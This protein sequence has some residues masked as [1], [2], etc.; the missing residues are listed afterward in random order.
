MSLWSLLTVTFFFLHISMHL[1]LSIILNLTTCGFF[2]RRFFLHIF[3][4]QSFHYG[5]SR[6]AIFFCNAV[7]VWV[8]IFILYKFLRVYKKNKVLKFPFP[9]SSVV[10]QFYG[11]L[12]QQQ[13]MMQ[14]YVR[15][16][17][18]QRAILQ[19]HTDFKDKVCFP[20]FVLLFLIYTNEHLMAPLLWTFAHSCSYLICQSCGSGAMQKRM[21]IHIKSFRSWSY[22]ISK[23]IEYFR[24]WCSLHTTITRVYT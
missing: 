9:L 22:W 1:S 24:K 10:F 21:Q 3:I 18:Y 14:D 12:S 13:N 8:Y 6:T 2:V 5:W 23:S 11:Y 4:C 15:T 16:G 7:I 17:T 19:N 20:Y